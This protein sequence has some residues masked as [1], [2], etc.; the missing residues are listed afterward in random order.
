MKEEIVQSD[1]TTTKIMWWLHTQLYHKSEE[2]P[3]ATIESVDAYFITG[4]KTYMERIIGTSK[5]LSNKRRIIFDVKFADL[6]YHTDKKI[7]DNHFVVG[8][9]LYLIESVAYIDEGEKFL[10]ILEKPMPKGSGTKIYLDG[11][12]YMDEIKFMKVEAIRDQLLH[13]RQDLIR[14]F[15]VMKIIDPSGNVTEFLPSE[16]LKIMHSVAEGLKKTKKVIN[17]TKQT[18]NARN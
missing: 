5:Y 4:R 8:N 14:W 9:H 13:E 10:E 15:D 18:V 11:Q 7:P 17:Y 2:H 16:H 12:L 6:Y 1:P 3:K